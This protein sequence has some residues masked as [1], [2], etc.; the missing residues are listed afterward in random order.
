MYKYSA[1]MQGML[2]VYSAAF[3]EEKI[4]KA[5][6]ELIEGGIK[7][8]RKGKKK[9]PKRIPKGTKVPKFKAMSESDNPVLS[10]IKERADWYRKSTKQSSDLE[11][12][13]S[14]LR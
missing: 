2:A 3:G 7:A 4:A 13:L 8:L 14:Q 10:P 1:Y 9:V 5:T 6:R 12:F 11:W